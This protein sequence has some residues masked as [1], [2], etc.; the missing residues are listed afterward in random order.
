MTDLHS[1]SN[2]GQPVDKNKVLKVSEATMVS[3]NSTS[4]AASASSPVSDKSKPRRKRRPPAQPWRKP[5]GMPKRYLSAYNLFYK[6]ERERMLKTA[7]T[8]LSEEGEAIKGKLPTSAGSP[9]SSGGESGEFV[10]AP[11]L[12]ELPDP[13][14]PRTNAARK[15]ARSSGIGFAN[16]TRIVAAKWKDLDPALKAPYEQVAQKDK[17]RRRVQFSRDYEPMR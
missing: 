7:D 2:K 4:S 11:A 16:L 15:H 10:P 13:D 17:E 3:P 12:P 6:D 1:D 14:A 9:L 8:P 5:K